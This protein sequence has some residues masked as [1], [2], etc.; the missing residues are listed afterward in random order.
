MAKSTI[1]APDISAYHIKLRTSTALAKEQTLCVGLL[2]NFR[3]P[4]LKENINTNKSEK[5]QENLKIALKGLL[6]RYIFLSFSSL[7]FLFLFRF[8]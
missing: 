1:W 4:E 7:F 5:A 8:I 6:A 2:R 3:F